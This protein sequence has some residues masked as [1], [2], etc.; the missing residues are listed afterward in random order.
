MTQ[1][2]QDKIKFNPISYIDPNGRVFEWEDQ[3]YRA[4]APDKSNFFKELIERG[5]FKRLEDKGWFVPTKIT[6]YSLENY[7]LILWH[8]KIDFIT[9]CFEWPPEM[10]REAAIL[11]VKISLELL[12]E[13]LILQDA[14]PWNISFENTNPIFLDVTSIVKPDKNIIWGAYQQFCN[15]FLYP[16]YLYSLGLYDYTHNL[17]MNYLDGVT[18]DACYALLPFKSKV[19][20]SNKFS[21]LTSPLIIGN[22]LRR[23]NVDSKIRAAAEN[24]GSKVDLAVARQKFFKKLLQE[25]KNIKFPAKKTVWT[26]YHSRM[27]K[28]E[29][30]EKDWDLK[31]RAVSEILDNINPKTVLDIGCNGGGYSVLAAKKSISVVAF[32]ADS[33]CIS[34]LFKISRKRQL[35]IT[36]LVLNL[37]NLSPQFG[38]ALEQ[39]PSAL[40]RLKA[41][42]GLALALIHHL[43][44]RYGQDFGQIV[45]TFD[46]LTKSWLLVEFVPKEDEKAKLLLSRR[47]DVFPWYNF[48]NFAKELNKFYSLEKVYDSYPEGRKL[49]LCKK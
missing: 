37:L 3:I 35:S 36:P 12:K 7:G 23:H 31:Q 14:Y 21:R 5:V 2:P 25:V 42:M 28:T 8:K 10:L 30:A 24:I 11:T 38:C 29:D 44:F 27:A 18:E 45:K 32:D 19:L 34:D 40:N 17:L 22:F 15:F 33:N 46:K 41:D 47:P 39:F 13:N 6:E 1:I 43:V 16:L 48:D 9:Y 4:L 49:I 20:D 26:G